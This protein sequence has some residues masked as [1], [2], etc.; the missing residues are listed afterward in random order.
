MSAVARDLDLS[1]R[2]FATLAAVLFA[3][4]YAAAAGWMCAF[5]LIRI[6]HGDLPFL[7]R[8]RERVARGKLTRM[9]ASLKPLSALSRRS[10]C[11]GF[12][13]DVSR[14]HLLQPVVTD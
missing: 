2:I 7:P 11:E 10:M 14:G 3:V 6:G 9:Q 8:C 1:S 13:A 5:F 12:G 4:R